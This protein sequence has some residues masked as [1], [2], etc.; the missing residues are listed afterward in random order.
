[1]ADRTT[2]TLITIGD[3]AKLLGVERHSVHALCTRGRLTRYG[4]RLRRMVDLAEVQAIYD[5]W[6]PGGDQPRPPV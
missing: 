1:M 5:E 3:A 2:R 4:N 6:N